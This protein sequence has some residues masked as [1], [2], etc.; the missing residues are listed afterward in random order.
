MGPRGVRQQ[1]RDVL[2]PPVA[3]LGRQ[4]DLLEG[5]SGSQRQDG[6]RLL[7]IDLGT[8]PRAA[9]VDSHLDRIESDDAAGQLRTK[10]RRSQL[11]TVGFGAVP[12]QR[13]FRG[14]AGRGKGGGLVA[15]GGRGEKRALD[16]E[17]LY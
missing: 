5:V 11:E 12:A 7:K 13:R 17:R 8:Q 15:L 9:V 6:G 4:V 3:H 10:R 14:Q 2:Q 16:F 1:R